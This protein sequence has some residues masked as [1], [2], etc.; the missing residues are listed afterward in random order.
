MLLVFAWFGVWAWG[1][2]EKAVE[3]IKG[4]KFEPAFDKNGKHVASTTGVE[5]PFHL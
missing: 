2:D 4:W 5:I 1:L 3:A